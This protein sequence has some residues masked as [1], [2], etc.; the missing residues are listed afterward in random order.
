[1]INTSQ[2]LYHESILIAI[3]TRWSA[4]SLLNIKSMKSWCNMT[5]VDLQTLYMGYCKEGWNILQGSVTTHLGV[6]CPRLTAKTD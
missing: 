5:T 3:Y 4:N 2:Q 6:D 1:M